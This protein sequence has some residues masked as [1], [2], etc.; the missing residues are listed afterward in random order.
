MECP[1]MAELF[2]VFVK[3]THFLCC[4]WL[5]SWVIEVKLDVHFELA[6]SLSSTD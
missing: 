3:F 5:R 4:L 6:H 2:D 1:K